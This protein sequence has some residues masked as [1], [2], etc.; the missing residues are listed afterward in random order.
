MKVEFTKAQFKTL[1]E[2]IYMGNWMATSTLDEIPKRK[3]KYD[4][5]ERLIFKMANEFG[6]SQMV[7]AENE[8]EAGCLPSRAFEEGPIR[9]IIDS[10]DDYTFWE[11]LA[12]RLA[13]R[14]IELIYGK[15]AAKEMSRD[16]WF[17]K[18]CEFENNYRKE[19]Q[20]YGLGRVG[21][22]R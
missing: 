21:L 3:Q 16:E 15:E 22:L 19:F 4:E 9:H 7:D 10:Y 20:R 13:V 14:D 12:D 6:L 17:G 8:E 18:W 2:L 11:E 1:V 5:M